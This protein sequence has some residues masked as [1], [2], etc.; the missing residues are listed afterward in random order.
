MLTLL[1][2]ILIGRHEYIINCLRE[3]PSRLANSKAAPTLPFGHASVPALAPDTA[4]GTAGRDKFRLADVVA[5][6]LLPDHFA[7]EIPQVV[8]AGATAQ[9]RAQIVFDDAEQT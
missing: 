4:H 5:G 6:L 7:E 2:H 1:A 3:W 9:A 8:I